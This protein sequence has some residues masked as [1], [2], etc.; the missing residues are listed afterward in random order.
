MSA[1]LE[2]QGAELAQQV[3]SLSYLDGTMFLDVLNRLGDTGFLREARLVS[4]VTSL[5]KS[6][7]GEE[8]LW[9]AVKD[10]QSQRRRTRLMHAARTGNLERARFLLARGARLEHKNMVGWTALHWAAMRGRLS[11]LHQLL[12]PEGRAVGAEVNA[13][14]ADGTTPLWWASSMGHLEAVRELLARGAGLELSSTAG[15][16]LFRA[17]FHGHL[18]VVRELLLCGAAVAARADDGNLPIIL[19]SQEGHREVVAELLKGG[20][21]VNA[22]IQPPAPGAAADGRTALH[23]ASRFGNTSTV[24]L[25]V[26]QGA[27]INAADAHCRTALMH[28]SC[29]GLVYTVKE[30][31]KLGADPAL[32][33]AHG[34]T[35][36]Q[37][38]QPC[39][40]TKAALDE[41]FS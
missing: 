35:A 13:R 6:T 21:D 20:A 27:D 7:R 41:L 28:A 12:A 40:S 5:C 32:M 19:A 25:L 24:R 22:S 39:C 2:L 10:V 26:A 29:C 38:V 15:T 37:L 11:V 4:A 23:L 34:Q 9:D 8:A 3:Q 31:L 18:P 16:P 14:A 30:L 1:S 36:Q 17:S 33:D